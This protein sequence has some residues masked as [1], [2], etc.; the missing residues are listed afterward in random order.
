VMRALRFFTLWWWAGLWK[1][2]DFGYGYWRNVWCW[3]RG[4]HGDIWWY[5]SGMS[6]DM[7]CRDCGEDLG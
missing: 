2:R 6:P 3:I 1:C 5:S 7:R 4:H